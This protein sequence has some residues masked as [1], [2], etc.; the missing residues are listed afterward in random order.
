MKPGYVWGKKFESIQSK[1]LTSEN[2][3][4]FKTWKNWIGNSCG[5]AVCTK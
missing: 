5:R 2:L 3:S 4:V 1:G